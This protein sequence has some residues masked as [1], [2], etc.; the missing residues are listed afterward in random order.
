V[1]RPSC[2][3]GPSVVPAS[4][5]RGVAGG[6]GGGASPP[7][8]P[9]HDTSADMASEAQSERGS[10][11]RLHMD[12]SGMVAYLRN[13]NERV[14]RRRWLACRSDT[15]Q[16]LAVAPWL[17]HAQRERGARQLAAG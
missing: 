16:G 7:D 14:G 4:N 15:A 17:R 3:P 12:E 13:N 9:P 6:G 11:R 1:L 5:A 10:R 8:P 2:V